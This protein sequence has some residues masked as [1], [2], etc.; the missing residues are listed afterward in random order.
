MNLLTTDSVIVC[1]HEL[2]RV[3]NDASQDFV[4]IGRHLVL[5]DDDPEGC[6]ISG[7]PNIGA[8]IMPCKTTLKVRAGYSQFVKIDGHSVC[9]DSLVGLTNGTPQGAVE[10]IVSRSKQSLVSANS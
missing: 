9:L 3:K 4:R 8:T 5:V 1:K 2:G 7:C 10:Y 6:S